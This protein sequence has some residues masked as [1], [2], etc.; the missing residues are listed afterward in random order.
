MNATYFDLKR[1]KVRETLLYIA[2]R[3]PNPTLHTVFK[4]MY[5]ADKR[6]L[7]Y[8]GRFIGGDT[9]IAMEYG[10]VPS[11]AYDMTKDTRHTALEYGFR[12]EGYHIVPHRD[13]D[14]HVLSESDTDCLDSAI[15]QYGHKTF[16]ELTDA[17]HDHA[18]LSAPENGVIAIE[19]IAA[20]L[21][22]ADQLIAHLRDQHPD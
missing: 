21:P 6:H 17:S 7:E 3:I 12:V 9:Y 1:D 16:G 10:P 14:I 20:T 5:F 19:A 11:A 13:A 4:I 22:N 8:Y 2:T 15:E 18:W